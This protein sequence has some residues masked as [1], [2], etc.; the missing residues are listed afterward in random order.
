MTIENY[1]QYASGFSKENVTF[2]DIRNALNDLQ[3]M[4]DEHGAFW[5]GIINKD[6][7]ILETHKDFTLIAVFDD[8]PENEI[9]RQGNNLKEIEML[10]ELFL[11]CDFD[12]VKTILK[13]PH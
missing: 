7:N 3:G 11:N 6:E 13:T 9:R 12:K 5:V 1:L 8:E 10:Y 4:D 2:E